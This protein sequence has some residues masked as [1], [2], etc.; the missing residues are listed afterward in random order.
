[1]KNYSWITSDTEITLRWGGKAMLTLG[2]PA[3]D[4]LV[5]QLRFLHSYMDLRADRGGEIV[6]QMGA[7]APHFAFIL[8]LTASRNPKLYELIDLCQLLCS[9]CV[10]IP[11]H[12][13]AVRRPDQLDARIMPMIATPGHGSFPSGHATQAMAIATLLSAV[14]DANPGHFPDAAARKALLFKQAERIAANRT[15]SGVHYPI[16]SW[17]GA[18]LGR[19]VAG[20]M[21]D[22]ATTAGNRSAVRDAQAYAPTVASGDD[23]YFVDAFHV[24]DQVVAGKTYKVAQSGPLAWLWSKAM[25]EFL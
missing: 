6:G 3:P 12:Y 22:A 10:M 18:M 9:H 8:G 2:N 5:S 15:V 17:A 19:E 21:V 24:T 7:L 14:V 13:L 1:L 16:D 11:K 23:D 20:I 25:A 4:L